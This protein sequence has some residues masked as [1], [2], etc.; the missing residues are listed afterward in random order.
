[1]QSKSGGV[2]MKSIE[3]EINGKMTPV[4][5]A[6]DVDKVTSEMREQHE[7]EMDNLAKLMQAQFES[8]EQEIRLELRK[9]AEKNR[10]VLEHMSTPICFQDDLCGVLRTCEREGD[11]TP[12]YDFLR[13][14]NA[15]LQLCREVKSP[16]QESLEDQMRKWMN[17]PKEEK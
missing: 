5:F 10:R 16:S 11:A 9:Q 7:K 14:M 3:V 1:M 15:G 8:R 12:A 6:D 4:C 2:Q 17:K 13:G